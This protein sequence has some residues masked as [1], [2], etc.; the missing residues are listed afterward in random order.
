VNEA[1]AGVN[2]AS[3][4]VNEA[5]AGAHDVLFVRILGVFGE[6]IFCL[7]VWGK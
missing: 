2:E 7:G 6:K 4:G 3:A 1:F 5:S